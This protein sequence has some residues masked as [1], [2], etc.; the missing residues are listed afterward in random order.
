[1]SPG[2]L[3]CLSVWFCRE[4]GMHPHLNDGIRVCFSGAEGLG[5]IN[6]VQRC[7]FITVIPCGSVT[8]STLGS[9]A[10]A[11][12][13][14]HTHTLQ[15]MAGSYFCPYF[16]VCLS[17]SVFTLPLTLTSFFFH[18][19]FSTH[20]LLSFSLSPDLTLIFSFSWSHSL[21]SSSSV[22]VL[23]LITAAAA[24]VGL[25]HTGLHHCIAWH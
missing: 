23:S 10:H 3:L 2:F 24:L 21:P 16:S 4:G 8:H 19:P 5:R 11:H 22:S 13:H 25:H 18:I 9:V 12:R 7:D 6:W 14:K 1:M 20:F 15:C 17:L